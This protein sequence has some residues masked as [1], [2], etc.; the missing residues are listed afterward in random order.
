MHAAIQLVMY[1]T[2]AFLTL[3]M[4]LMLLNIFFGLIG[5]DLEL[6]SAGSETV[7]AGVSSLIE[8]L[9]FWLVVTFVP[10]GSRAL[11]IPVVIVALIYKVAHHENWGRFDVF[12]LLAFQAVIGFLGVSLLFGHFQTAIFILVG[13]GVVLAVIAFFARGLWD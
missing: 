3:G 6:R 1:W 11:I 7:I 10:L 5:N 8:A 4:A 13:F 2:L 9:S 12:M